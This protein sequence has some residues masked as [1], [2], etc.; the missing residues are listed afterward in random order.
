MSKAT[1]SAW[2]G[3][4]SATVTG[5]TSGRALATSPAM[6]SV[7]VSRVPSSRPFV[8]QT[9]TVSGRTYGA[10]CAAMPRTKRDEVTKTTTSFSAHASSTLVV[11]ATSAGSSGSFGSGITWVLRSRST[12]CSDSD[13]TTTSWPSSEKS[14][15]SASPHAPLPRT[16]TRAR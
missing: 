14:L 3:P 1:S 15:A 6:T 2:L 4:E 10:A 8:A 11:R 5:V 13:Q 9:S 16:P 12:A 7:I